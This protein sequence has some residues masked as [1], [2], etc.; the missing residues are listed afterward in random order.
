MARTGT[1]SFAFVIYHDGAKA[2]VHI[3]LIK[4]YAPT[5]VNELCNRKLVYWGGTGLMSELSDE[6]YYLADVVELGVTMA[7]LIQRLTR[8]NMAIPELIFDVDSSAPSGLAANVRSAGKAARNARVAK[9]RRLAGIISDEGTS[10]DE[11][12]DD[13]DSDDDDDDVVPKKLLL[14]EKQKNAALC[15]KL[16]A[17]RKEK[18]HL[19][20]RHD[21][22]EDHFLNKLESLLTARCHHCCKENGVPLKATPI[23]IDDVDDSETEEPA[24]QSPESASIVHQSADETCRAM[25]NQ[26]PDIAGS[27]ILAE[28]N[29]KVHLGNDVYIEKKEWE[30]LQGLS[31]DSLFCKHLAKLVW[32]PALRGRSV[33]GAL[34]QRFRK[35]SNA[36]AKPALSPHKLQAVGNAFD[37]YLTK[38]GAPRKEKKSRRS[39]MNCYLAELLRDTN[40][41]LQRRSSPVHVALACDA[42]AGIQ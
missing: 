11:G 40:A 39:K 28:L 24:S 36:V 4:Q 16:A 9:R 30:Q 37:A 8:R 2:I 42:P 20:A 14:E 1:P 21:R 10:S 32:G 6:H 35:N 5:S 38:C 3:S 34:C 18:D 19:Q 33:T 31:R 26:E 41:S 22:L 23:T 29:G 15:R 7:D 13:D 27:E 25:C 12:D 17:L